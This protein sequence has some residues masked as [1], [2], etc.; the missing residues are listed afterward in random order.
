MLKNKDI[1]RIAS[2]KTKNAYSLVELSVVITIMS[3]L[4]M[5]VA[6]IVS[7]SMKKAQKNETQEKMQII[8]NSMG[9]FLLRNQRLPCPA[10]LNLAE[11]SAGYGSDESITNGDCN[12]SSRIFSSNTSG[13]I[14][15]FVGAVP[16]TTLG[17]SSDMAKDE[18]GNKITYIISK[19]ATIATTATIFPGNNFSFGSTTTAY[20]NQVL[21]VLE[22]ANN[23]VTTDRTITGQ[24]IF[25]LISHGNNQNCAYPANGVS[26]NS[27]C[28][29]N[30]EE[31]NSSKKYTA[32][33]TDKNIIYS[34]TNPN[35]DDIVLFKTKNQ[36]AT[37]FNAHHLLLCSISSSESTN[38][39]TIASGTP[40]ST[41]QSLFYEQ[42][43]FNIDQ[44]N[45]CQ[46]ICGKYGQLFYS[47]TTCTTT[48]P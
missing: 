22:Y 14:N 33:F 47:N 26:P 4:M 41:A 5:G 23:P 28:P 37:D 1:F 34:S 27:S 24:A 7:S 45:S 29:I 15:I 9:K 19:N 30:N 31:I 44:N 12:N 32:N 39:N 36:I 2:L 13:N 11:S 6:S 17:L 40:R 38:Y 20:D 21:T 42:N 18:F 8:Y 35:F 46:L 43:L 3:I 25:A 16:T 48:T 10:R